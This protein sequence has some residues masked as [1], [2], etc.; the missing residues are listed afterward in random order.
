M[1]A[2][3]SLLSGLVT[4]TRGLGE[5]HSLLSGLV[6]ETAAYRSA[7]AVSRTAQPAAYRT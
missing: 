7:V 2:K 1:T 4:E 5:K 3:H 6:T